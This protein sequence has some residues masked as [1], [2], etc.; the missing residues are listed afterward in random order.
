MWSIWMS[1]RNQT[2]RALWSE[3]EKKLCTIKFYREN[4]L[5]FHRPAALTDQDPQEPGAPQLESSLGEDLPRENSWSIH[6]SHIL[7][8]CVA[9][10]ITWVL[11]SRLRFNPDLKSSVPQLPTDWNQELIGLQ[12]QHKIFQVSLSFANSAINQTT[13]VQEP[14]RTTFVCNL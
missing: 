1:C 4:S 8:W 14:S 10:E 2:S 3:I 12:V 7:P 5:I 9:S 6:D 11:S 13:E